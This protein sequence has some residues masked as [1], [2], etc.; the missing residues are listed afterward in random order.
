M[1][2]YDEYVSNYNEINIVIHLI[3]TMDY[4]IRSKPEWITNRSLL[5]DLQR[6]LNT[7]YLHTNSLTDYMLHSIDIMI[8]VNEI[9]Q[10]IYKPIDT[11]KDPPALNPRDHGINEFST[12]Y[13]SWT[14]WDTPI[15]N[16]VST[17]NLFV[18]NIT[19]DLT[20]GGFG[21][22]SDVAGFASK[23]KQAGIKTKISLGGGGGTYD[24]LWNVITNNNVQQLADKLVNYC[25]INELSGVDFDIECFTSSD[26]RP[27]LQLL[28]GKLIKLFKQGDPA[29]ETSYCVNAGFGPNFPW[30]GIAKNIIIES[31]D[32]I[33]IMSYYDPIEQEKQWITGWTNW[34]ISNYGYTPSRISVALNDFDSHSYDI[35]ELAK[36]AKSQGL[37][38]AY[39]CYNPATPYISDTSLKTINN[40]F[41][42]NL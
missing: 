9:T 18:G 1:D 26:D 41:E 42:T 28:C 32:R 33:Y 16:Y 15:P 17:I 6:Q 34:L 2:H 35:G 24:N 3:D 14:S 5:I 11:P 22:V 4:P 19:N 20:I 39:W 13:I 40:M 31:I 21:T 38:V 29:L 37:S 10:N 25:H 36:W 23:M 7:L 30:Q 8:K 27:D 12:W